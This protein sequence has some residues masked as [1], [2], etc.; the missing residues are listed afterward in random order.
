MNQ[1]TTPIVKSNNKKGRTLGAMLAV[2]TLAILPARA[3]LDTVTTSLTSGAATV[4]TNVG[5]VLVAGIGIFVLL[6][7]VQKIRS[8]M[9][10]SA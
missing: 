9:R 2:S 4:A 8:A 3:D 10:A 7:G 6:W 5:L 1:N